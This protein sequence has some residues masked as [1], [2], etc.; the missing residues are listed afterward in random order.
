MPNASEN[1][2]RSESHD[3]EV[4]FPINR[5]LSPLIVSLHSRTPTQSPSQTTQANQVERRTQSDSFSSSHLSFVNRLT[6][7]RLCFSILARRLP[8]AT[9]TESHNASSDSGNSNA[10]PFS[11]LNHTTSRSTFQSLDSRSRGKS[12]NPFRRQ[13]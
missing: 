12:R 5:R 11:F 3:L 1:R 13:R 8:D 4:R 6:P 9:R 7:F 2:Q 10:Y